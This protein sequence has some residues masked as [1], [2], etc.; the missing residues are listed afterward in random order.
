MTESATHDQNERHSEVLRVLQSH[1]EHLQSNFSQ[2]IVQ[3]EQSIGGAVD[4]RIR[5]IEQL[6][7]GQAQQLASEQGPLLLQYKNSHTGSKKTW[8]DAAP[9][10]NLPFPQN[11]S[12]GFRVNQFLTT[13]TGGCPCACHRSNALSSPGFINHLLGRVFVN[14]AGL[15]FLTPK[16][17]ST[18]CVKEQSPRV[19]IEYW[20]PLGVFW[21]QII[22]LEAIKIPKVGPQMQLRF[23]RRVPDSAQAVQFAL[24]G[25][26]RGLQDLFTRGMA[27]PRDV[28]ETR[29]YSLIRVSGPLLFMFL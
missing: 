29:G 16:C 26:I 28:S 25:N 7:Q 21:S 11:Q 8:T 10:V 5:A 15:P 1:S 20:F 13:C 27:S 3:V 22:R 17:D 4:R 2:A 19:S 6:L 18:Q 9:H 12:L 23:L 14:Y 24:G